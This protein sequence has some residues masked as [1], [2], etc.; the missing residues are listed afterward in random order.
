MRSSSSPRNSKTTSVSAGNSDTKA[1]THL[2]NTD[3]NQPNAASSPLGSGGDGSYGNTPNIDA[4][5]ST[6]LPGAGAITWSDNEWPADGSGGIDEG[7]SDDKWSGPGNGSA[8]GN[9]ET[10]SGDD[11]DHLGNGSG[12]VATETTAEDDVSTTLRS[13]PSWNSL[14][15][16]TR[17]AVTSDK[18]SDRSFPSGKVDGNGGDDEKKATTLARRAGRDTLAGNETNLPMDF[19]I[20]DLTTN[21]AQ[22]LDA[23]AKAYGLNVSDDHRTTRC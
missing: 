3:R 2:S 17:A 18:H 20:S 1:S 11:K 7:S 4:G 5:H 6:G 8:S 12:T 9:G 15:S 13:T 10:N 23:V 21:E 14:H 22:L 19:S 16:T